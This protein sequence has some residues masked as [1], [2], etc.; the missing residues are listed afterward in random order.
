MQTPSLLD[1]AANWNTYEWGVFGDGGG[2]QANFS[3]VG[4][5]F[6][7]ITAVNDGN[8]TAPSCLVEGFTGETNNLNIAEYGSNE[9]PQAFPDFGVNEINSSLP[10]PA[11]C[12][13]GYIWGDTHILTFGQPPALPPSSNF[14]SNSALRDFQASG[15]Y[16]LAKSGAFVAQTQQVSGAPVWPNAAMNQDIAAQIGKSDVAVCGA[17]GAQPARLVI[18]GSPVNLGL[19]TATYLP[20][21][22]DVAFRNVTEAGVTAPG[23]VMRD[24]SGNSVV[25]QPMVGTSS[26]G[27]TNYL[28]ATVGLGTWPTQ[29]SGLIANGPGN[30][31]DSVEASTGAVVRGPEYP[32]TAYYDEYGDSWRVP[33]SQSLLSACGNKPVVSNPTAPFSA[34]NLT[35]AERETANKACVGA[36]VALPLLSSCEIDVAVLGPKAATQIYRGLPTNVTAGAI[37]AKRPTPP[38]PPTNASAKGGKASATVSF[39]PPTSNGG[40]AIVGYTVTAVDTTKP[41]NGGQTASG[42]SSPI[43]ISGLTP[44]DSYTFTVTA[45]NEAGTSPASN[46]S[47]AVRI[48]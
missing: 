22:G 12:V 7:A 15:D 46:P 9:P 16:V 47:N 19:G 44:G 30:N 37:I 25:A 38:G 23:Y 28:N 31:V 42:T 29:V 20:G 41:A 18:N 33:A 32:F 36:G 40:N 8:T 11:S 10:A 45:T 35:T 5:K 24:L 26:S 2:S 13:S 34:A 21:G 3:N 48:G 27:T 14:Y 39:K 4:T 17:N 1:L 6:G 43:V